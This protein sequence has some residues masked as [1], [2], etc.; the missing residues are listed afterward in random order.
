M[1]VAPAL[2]VERL[3]YTYPGGS[4]ALRE[5]SFSIG[6]GERVAVL[7]AKGAGKSTLLWCLVGILRGEGR[8]VVGGAELARGREAEVRRRLGLAFS[9]PDDQLFMPTVIRDLAFG[10]R[11]AGVQPQAALEKARAAAE[12]VGLEGSLVERAPHELSSGERRR[13][14]LA[15]VLTLEP[16]VLALDEPTNSLDAP[17]RAALARTLAGLP[18]AQLIATHDLDFVG[19]VCS[20]ALVLVR[21]RLVADEGLEDL[22]RDKERLTAYGLLAPGG[23]AGG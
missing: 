15:A 9:E 21:G 4:S 13:A 22:L 3:S 8:V 2:S 6:P 10:P 1:V 5:V 19:R 7:G 18:C 12:Q 14:A 16:E 23:S 20:R 17:G 11:A